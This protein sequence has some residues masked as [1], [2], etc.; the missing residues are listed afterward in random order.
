MSLQYHLIMQECIQEGESEWLV[1]L[2]NEVYDKA[3]TTHK[4]RSYSK[5][6]IECDYALI[7]AP[8]IPGKDV[9]SAIGFGVT[10]PKAIGSNKDRMMIFQDLVDIEFL[11]I[12]IAHEYAHLG[13]EESKTEFEQEKKAFTLELQVAKLARKKQKWLRYNKKEYPERLRDMRE[14]GLIR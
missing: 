13:D 6:G 9:K 2:L 1:P 12:A 4:I 3:E 11:D 14:M 7:N 8:D 5:Y 10:F